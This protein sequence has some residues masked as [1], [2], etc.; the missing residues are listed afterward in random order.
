VTP[1]LRLTFG[2]SLLHS[3]YGSAILCDSVIGPCNS[4][5]APALVDVK[6]NR[7]PRAPGTTGSIAVDYTIPREVAGGEVSLHV[8]AAYRSRTYWTPFEYKT[9]S[10][11]PQWMTNAQIR[12]D[13][14]SWYVAGYV[15]NI[16]DVLYVTN[17]I[18]S[19]KLST[20]N[21]LVGEPAVFDRYAA[22]RTYGVRIGFSY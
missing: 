3:E 21:G 8:D 5:D 15:Q 18:G 22:P 20:A 9:H 7:L 12:Y 17:G 2:L 19:G 16:F 6:G 11:D 1:N 14:G 4:P 13:R 10:V